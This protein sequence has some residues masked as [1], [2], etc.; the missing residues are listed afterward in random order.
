MDKVK[1]RLKHL[2]RPGEYKRPEFCWP[3]PDAE[4]VQV[5]D[6]EFCVSTEYISSTGCR[7]DHGTNAL[8]SFAY[9]TQLEVPRQ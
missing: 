1:K 3:V 2:F 9:G 7:G 6:S 8:S 5:S 4:P